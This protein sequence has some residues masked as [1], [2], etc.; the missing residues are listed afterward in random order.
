[1]D[2]EIAKFQ[3]VEAFVDGHVHLQREFEPLTFIYSSLHNFTMAAS[4]SERK[5][6]LV[7]Y[8]FLCETDGGGQ[9][10]RLVEAVSSSDMAVHV[11]VTAERD[12]LFL[13]FSDDTSL[14]VVRGEQIVTK[15]NLEIL[16]FGGH[17]GSFCGQSFE[18]VL[19][20]LDA[21]GERLNIL[22]WGVGK[23]LGVRGA[24][25]REV[26]AGKKAGEG[27]LLFLGDNGN[28]PWFWPLPKIFAD[29]LQ[30]GMANLPGSDPLSFAHHESR[31]GSYG[32][33]LAVEF[34]SEVPFKSLHRQIVRG[35]GD[36]SVFG[37]PCSFKNFFID[38]TSCQFIKK[39]KNL[40]SKKLRLH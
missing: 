38:Q 5:L 22:P 6:P 35:Y 10:E 7:F 12:S 9:F 1:M 27:S 39:I 31:A 32:F 19:A 17:G 15:E 37:E 21:S 36:I 13:S 18:Q 23:W 40:G 2:G 34:D 26:V 8:L 20:S 25:I 16:T 14:C 30:K 3:E 33:R 29:G 11:V 24:L 28:R 4:N